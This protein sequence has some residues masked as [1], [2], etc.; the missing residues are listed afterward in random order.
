MQQ[1]L[2]LKAYI[3]DIPDFPKKGIV[4]KDITPLLADKQAFKYAIDSLA[5]LVTS[6]VDLVLGAEARGFIIGGA[7]AYRLGAGFI[8]ARKPGKLPY[9][10]TSALYELE[11]GQD[12]LEIHE[13]SI[14][15]GEKVLIV[16]DVLATGGTA[17]AKAD[18]VEKLGGKVVS[19]AFLIEL[20]FLQGRKKLKDYN[21]QSLITY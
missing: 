4:F 7:L 13:D 1:L 19:L 20:S 18:L 12:A 2:D 6:Q 3:R 5:E 21:V 14:T 10:V 16:D 17:R 15:P 11:Y 8:P 9:Q